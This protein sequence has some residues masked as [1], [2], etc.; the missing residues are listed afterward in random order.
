MKFM[1][2]QAVIV[3]RLIMASYLLTIVGAFLPWSCSGD[4]AW[5]CNPGIRISTQALMIIPIHIWITVLLIMILGGL[6]ITQSRAN[7]S[8]NAKSL[9]G[10]L[11]LAI[12]VFLVL[13]K[14]EIDHGGLVPTIIAICL[15]FILSD[16]DINKQ[17]YLY[18]SLVG[19]VFQLS[20]IM[21]NVFYVAVLIF[22]ERHIFGGTTF[23]YG[24]FISLGGTMLSLVLMIF[25]I[26]LGN[27]KSLQM[28]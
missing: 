8:N 1:K 21:M 27:R 2:P 9:A 14:S 26:K 5:L 13:T 25:L 23:S 18:F 3:I 4:I 22:A 19:S 7:K 17:N 24:I 11:L 15:T 6:L 28:E 12:L 16:Y 10:F 20:I